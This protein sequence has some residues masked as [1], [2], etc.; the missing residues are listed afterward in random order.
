M[1]LTTGV[2]VIVALVVLYSTAWLMLAH[3]ARSR[4]DTYIAR[5]RD[6][7]TNLSYGAE[8]TGG[9]P[10]RLE[11]RFSDLAVDG[12]P[13]MAKAR[14]TA[15]T[16]IAWARPWQLDAWRFALPAGVSID[17][18]QGTLVLGSLKGTLGTVL[19]PGATPGGQLADI[20]V[21]SLSITSGDRTAK[22]A[23]ATLDLR[24]PPTPPHAHEEPLFSISLRAHQI[25]LAAGVVPLG[26]QVD[27]LKLDAT[28]RG[29]VPPGKLAD[30]LAGWR[31][32][33]GTI[34]LQSVDLAWGPLSLA[35]DGTLT[36]D[37][38]MQP[39]GAF[40]AR[41]MGYD[42][43]LDALIASGGIKQNDA[44]LARMGLSMMAQRGADGTPQLKTPVSVQA[45]AI[46]LGPARLLKL[47]RID[48]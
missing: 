26:Q 31:D 19:G 13:H 38:D 20:Q 46:F 42:A 12:L 29:P 14:L 7:G 37:K 4:V 40:S 21:E 44:A 39:L 24:L 33:G 36:L 25:T 47:N 10:L 15:P 22:L 5:E 43:I 1:N 8:T 30:A 32:D 48:W 23:A 3:R 11:V 9:F 2:A 16:A 17:A 35:A 27:H 28:W 6:R 34:E 45:N 41:I 18:P